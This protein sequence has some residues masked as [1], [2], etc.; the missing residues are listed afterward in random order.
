M[1]SKYKSF[2]TAATLYLSSDISFLDFNK[3][4]DPSS[5]PVKIYYPSKSIQ[6][7]AVA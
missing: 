2:E 5:Q 1:I 6:V 4:T 3:H 7:I